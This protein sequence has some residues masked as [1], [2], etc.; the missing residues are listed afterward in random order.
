M[1]SSLESLRD[2]HGARASAME[3]G[4]H[5]PVHPGGV[6]L[7]GGAGAVAGEAPKGP[8][9][10]P[11]GSRAVPGEAPKEA[12]PAGRVA[13]LGSADMMKADYLMQREQPGNALLLVHLIE[14]FSLDPQL[15]DVERQKA[16]ARDRSL[17]RIL[18]GIEGEVAITYYASEDIPPLLEP[19][20]SKARE[21][22]DGL[23]KA[24]GGR[25]SS[26][27]VVPEEEGRAWAAEQVKEYLDARDKG[28][29]P[30]E[31]RPADT[32]SDLLGGGKARNDDQIARTAGSGRRSG[33]SG[34]GAPR[35]SAS[36]RSSRRT[37]WR[38]TDGRSE[39]R[40]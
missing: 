25:I 27:V 24:S 34:R 31:P 33:H 18:S 38:S 28:A 35:R 5:G 4:S 29:K 11:K 3:G 2:P 37:S 8:A 30:R 32:I 10:T 12:A 36:G 21:A 17:Q 14:A 39:S 26:K 6:R 23:V 1:P 40:A 15:L 19:V 20:R 13:I 9:A 22:L 7:D 16:A